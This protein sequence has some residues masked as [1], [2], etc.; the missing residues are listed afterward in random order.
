MSIRMKIVASLIAVSLTLMLSY[1]YTAQRVFENDKISYIF[2][3][4]QNKVQNIIS[5]FHQKLDDA[6]WFSRFFT[7]YNKGKA[8]ELEELKILFNDQ[9]ALTDIFIL[10][11]DTQ[12]IET[13]ISKS[14]TPTPPPTGQIDTT[15][16]G[17]SHLKNTEFLLSFPNTEDNKLILL[18]VLNYDFTMSSDDPYQYVLLSN[19]NVLANSGQTHIQSSDLTTYFKNV[20]VTESATTSSDVINNK[21]YLIST[22]PTRHSNIRF[23]SIISQDLAFGALDELYNKTIIYIIISV[24]IIFIIS[25]LL[26]HRITYRMQLLTK[27]A[28]DIG[29]GNFDVTPPFESKDEVGTLANA[30]RTMGQQIKVLFNQKLDKDRMERELQ[31]A[32]LIQKQLFP[33]QNN[34][35]YNDHFLSGY[36]TTSTE[37]GGDWWY[38]FQLGFDVYII[39]AD[40]TGHGIPAALIT[41]ASNAI[42]SHIREYDYT[43]EDMVRIWDETVFQSSRGQIYMTGQICRYNLVT[44]D[45]EFVNLGHEMPIIFSNQKKTCVPII[46]EKN[47]CLGE[48]AKKI[49]TLK[50]FRL[51]KGETIVLYTDGILELTPDLSVMNERRFFKKIQNFFTDLTGPF[52]SAQNFYSSMIKDSSLEGKTLNDDVTLIV[53]SRL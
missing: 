28:E 53:F 6:L 3:D 17:L 11:T 20:P 13:I 27:T 7:I 39:I 8:E 29:A 43:L 41:S 23:G 50:K 9:K 31:T 36:Y 1:I 35:S 16:V 44:G 47:F 5:G 48:R 37:C 2:E 15:S 30:F 24:L 22:V 26:S 10:N 32:S 52:D 34:V 18:L 38:H 19:G 51:E 40:A 14:K 46:L 4:Q 45:G 25:Y 12:K 21:E 42:F 33:E 49:P